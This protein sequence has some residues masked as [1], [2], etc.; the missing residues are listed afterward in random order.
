[1]TKEEHTNDEVV[2]QT[3]DETVISVTTIE[4]RIDEYFDEKRLII[5]EKIGSAIDNVDE[6]AGGAARA[7]LLSGNMMRSVLALLCY[8]A[9]GGDGDADDVAAVIE[10]A[11]NIPML[12]DSVESCND[13]ARNVDNGIKNAMS[14]P[15][16]VVKGN[17][18]FIGNAL[19][20]IVGSPKVVNDGINVAKAAINDTLAIVWRGEY[21][22]DSPYISSIKIK[23]SLAMS[24][25]CR[26]GSEKARSEEC[27]ELCH[28]YGR[29]L[30]VAY[31]VAEDMCKL[32]S[33]IENDD[34]DCDISLA[35]L[36]GLDRCGTNAIIGDIDQK[37]LFKEMKDEST[38]E[39][40]MLRLLLVY[41]KYT[42]NAIKAAERLPSGKHRDMLIALPDHIFA[43]LRE[44]YGID[45]SNDS[46]KSFVRQKFNIDP[47]VE[48][49]INE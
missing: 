43:G 37:P 29:N 24:I 5:A 13:Y 23:D 32:I 46:L 48:I 20:M 42:R 41:N 7:Y 17:F 12:Q 30:G 1:M 2:H 21:A 49:V 22:N 27:V 14:V 8:E 3:E 15:D 34:L 25:A 9:S 11:S 16:E 26:A 45:N 18:A 38:I 39:D 4:D 47:S 6:D 36:Y 35:M 31:T 10:T 33:C 40:A 19:G 28:I 44:E